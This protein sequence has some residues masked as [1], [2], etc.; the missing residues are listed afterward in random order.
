MSSVPDQYIKNKSDEQAIDEGCT[1]DIRRA[2]RVRDFLRKF[3]RQSIGEFSGKPLELLPWQFEDLVAPL[4]SWARPDG[5]RRFRQAGVW[6]PKNNGKSTLCSGL[7]LYHLIADGEQGAQVVNIASTV[8]QA[9]IVFRG[10]AD[11]V[12]Q[13]PQLN[14]KLWVRKNIKTIEYDKTRSTYKTMSGERGGGKHGYSISLLVFDELAEVVDRELWETMRHNLVKRKNSLLVSI[15]T[16]GFRKESVGYEQFIYAQKVANSEII[17]THFFPLIYQAKPEQ[18]WKTLET[19]V[20]CNPS[21]N[22]TIR[23]SDIHALLTEA[24]N[25]PRKEAAYRTLHLGTWTGFSTNWIGSEKWEACGEDFREED[26]HGERVFVGYDGSYKGDLTS[27]VLLAKREDKVYLMP[28]F[29][30]PKKNAERRQKLD[31]VPYLVWADDPKTNLH[32]TP[33]DIIDPAYVRRQLVEDSKHFRF[34]EIGFDS[35]TGFEESRQLLEQEHGWTFID[36]PQRAKFLG[37]AAS[38]FERLVLG[39]ATDGVTS[40]RHPKN[41]IL[42]W[43]LENCATKE[44]PD[45]IHIMKGQGDHNRIDGIIATIIGMTRLMADQGEGD[46]L[47]TL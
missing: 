17:D 15:S 44:T 30:L 28:R 16:A 7:S 5:T 27:Y 31:H 22:V 29:F 9:S 34:A 42:D 1:F 12:S 40:L 43:C 19:F 21:Y 33:G 20:S 2:E 3:C 35:N 38:Y 10:A 4:Y 13:S 11:M 36:V 47:L 37:G 18:D 32:L 23:E 46:W 14:D 8:E 26:F 25:E 6:C 41:P 24:K 39:T 45:G